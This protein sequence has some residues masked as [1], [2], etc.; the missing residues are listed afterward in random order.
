MLLW[1]DSLI[2]QVENSDKDEILVTVT[3][4]SLAVSAFINI[5]KNHGKRLVILN[6]GNPVVVIS[7]YITDEARGGQDDQ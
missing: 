4:L 6:R 3:E 5:V 2:N 7:P 1:K